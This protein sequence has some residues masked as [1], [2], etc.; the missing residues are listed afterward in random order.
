MVNR[1]LLAR[2]KNSAKKEQLSASESYTDSEA[3]KSDVKK[4]AMLIDLQ[5]NEPNK[6]TQGETFKSS[7]I[8]QNRSLSTIQS[9]DALPKHTRPQS[10]TP[11]GFENVLKQIRTV[12]K[13]D[14]TASDA[15]TLDTWERDSYASLSKGKKS[16]LSIEDTLASKFNDA[17]KVDEHT[18]VIRARSPPPPPIDIKANFNLS[19]ERTS[20]WVKTSP[21][22]KDAAALLPEKHNAEPEFKTAPS[23]P[24]EAPAITSKKPYLRSNAFVRQKRRSSNQSTDST[25]TE[26]LKNTESQRRRIEHAARELTDRTKRHSSSSQST[27]R[28]IRSSSEHH[29]SKDRSSNTPQKQYPEGTNPFEILIEEL[30]LERVFFDPEL[31]ILN[32]FCLE[33]TELCKRT[34]AKGLFVL[35]QAPHYERVYEAMRS[36]TKDASTPVVDGPPPVDIPMLHYGLFLDHFRA[37]SK[38]I[39]DPKVPLPHFTHGH[40]LT[41]ERFKSIVDGIFHRR[42][43]LASSVGVSQEILSDII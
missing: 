33:Y 26:N 15:T 5:T 18:G 2:M 24:S 12:N 13:P 40:R 1:K 43:F 11:P 25:G 19:D 3:D 16:M 22:A 31:D 37:S 23:T 35:R 8:G 17:V 27:P 38:K 28:N 4:E 9:E 42:R 21:D 29:R 10:L 20:Q 7:F 36:S 32:R 34:I 30:K 39:K 14:S 6:R 41:Q